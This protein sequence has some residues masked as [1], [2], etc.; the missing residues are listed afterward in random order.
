M[1]LRDWR[2]ADTAA[3]AMALI[4]G[5]RE[6]PHQRDP[7]TRVYVGCTRKTTLGEHRVCLCSLKSRRWML[8]CFL[9]VVVFLDVVVVIA[10]SILHN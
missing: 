10:V 7:R 5:W 1:R 3:A 9:V 2:H 4:V 6:K 8:V